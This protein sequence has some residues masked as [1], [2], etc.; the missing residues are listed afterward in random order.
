M[1][2]RIFL[3]VVVAALL[4]ASWNLIV[5]LNLDRFLSIFLLQFFMGLMGLAMLAAFPLPAAASF[6]FALA[7]GALHMGYNLFLARSY[8]I[9]VRD[10]DPGDSTLFHHPASWSAEAIEDAAGGAMEF[11]APLV[12]P[13]P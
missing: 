7:S 8:R 3:A 11:A 9:Q 4:H 2:L 13:S 6:P 10:T 5:K 1:D 12:A